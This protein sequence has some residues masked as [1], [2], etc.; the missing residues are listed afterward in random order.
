MKQLITLTPFFLPMCAAFGAIVL[1]LI[2]HFASNKKIAAQLEKRFLIFFFFVIP[3]VE[4]GLLRILIPLH[5]TIYNLSPVSL[6]VKIG[7]YSLIALI[8]NAWFRG[9]VKNSLLLLLADPLLCLLML[10]SVFASLMSNEVEYSMRCSITMIVITCFSSHIANKY[11]LLEI[12]GFV[13]SGSKWVTLLSIPASLL[14]PSGKDAKGWCGVLRYANWLGAYV[15]LASA[16]AYIN[17]TLKSSNRLLSYFIVACSFYVVQMSTS[18]T[19]KLVIIILIAEVVWLSFMQKLSFK[20]SFPGILF[21]MA[22]SAYLMYWLTGGGV[23]YI[24]VDKLGKDMTLTGRTEFWPQL[25]DKINA[26]PF[27]GYGYGGFWQTWKG[28]DDP[29]FHIS[30]KNGFR[31]PQAHNGFIEMGLQVGWFGLGL[32]ALSYFRNL[33]LA[34]LYFSR[35]GKPESAAPIIFLTFLVIGNITADRLFS[36]EYVWVYYVIFCVRINMEK[37]LS[38]KNVNPIIDHE[39]ANPNIRLNI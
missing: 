3:G 28:I 34:V 5:L 17:T 6:G 27:F 38:M 2:I 30:T 14:L 9:F 36:P 1:I 31:P 39:E 16:F 25:I 24:I 19:G 26:S 37:P 7:F 11:S 22:V 4:I 18:G 23:E 32:F 33:F 20:W 29:A 12:F 10:H 8:L 35:T 15:G 21:F 13:S